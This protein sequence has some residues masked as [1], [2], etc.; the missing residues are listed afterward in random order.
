MTKKNKTNKQQ[1][2]ANQYCKKGYLDLK[3]TVLS[4]R[5]RSSVQIIN[6]K[7]VNRE[8]RD[9]LLMGDFFQC[10]SVLICSYE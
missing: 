2:D 3:S 6:K 1:L 4:T 5:L 7:V 9:R 10:C 8:K